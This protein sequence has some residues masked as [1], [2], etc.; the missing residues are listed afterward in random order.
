MSHISLF[1]RQQARVQS[2]T[3]AHCLPTSP[4][5]AG[6]EGAAEPGT[7]SPDHPLKSLEQSLSQLDPFTHAA[8]PLTAA[9][10][11]PPATLLKKGPSRLGM[12][13]RGSSF[14]AFE[15]AVEPSDAGHLNA[16]DGA[17]GAPPAEQGRESGSA[18]NKGKGPRH[19]RTTRQALPSAKPYFACFYFVIEKLVI[20]HRR[21]IREEDFSSSFAMLLISL[22]DRAA[23]RHPSTAGNHKQNGRE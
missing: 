11:E 21:C 5:G 1:L 3:L 20:W 2:D 18:K 6:K 19:R 8:E 17:S 9:P 13:L 12:K 10:V 7:L 14:E 23:S 22:F 16:P 4:S 15:D